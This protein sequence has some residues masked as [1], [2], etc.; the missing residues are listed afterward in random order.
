MACWRAGRRA[1]RF[2]GVTLSGAMVGGVVIFI[3]GI[4]IACL[5]S[6]RCV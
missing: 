1:L 4:F 2:V 5:M 6:G 3:A